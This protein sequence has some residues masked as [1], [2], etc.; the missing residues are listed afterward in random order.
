MVELTR[1]EE[2]DGKPD[3]SVL[4][5][6]HDGSLVMQGGPGIAIIPAAEL[7][8]SQTVRPRWQ[9][10]PLRTRGK[11]AIDAVGNLWFA[12]QNVGVHRVSKEDLDGSG[13]IEPD[14]FNIEFGLVAIA[15]NA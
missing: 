6:R 14:E 12:H 3:L 7:N 10:M 5:F 13:P 2:A 15:I 8:R 1:N 9:T 11:G 4:M